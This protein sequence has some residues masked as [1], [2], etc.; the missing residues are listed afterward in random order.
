MKNPEERHYRIVCPLCGRRQED[1]GLTLTCASD[2][3][4]ALLHTEYREKEFRP[5]PEADGIFRYADWLPVVRS[6]PQAGRTVVFRSESLSAFLGM[7]GLRIAFNGYWPERGAFLETCTFKEL[8]AYTV[9]GRL[10]EEPVA[11]VVASAGNTAAAFASVCSRYAKPCL[12]IVPEGGLARLKLRE[13]LHPAVRLVVMDGADYSDAIALS[14]AV[15]KLPGFLLEGGVR[16]VGRRDGL[17]TVMYAAMEEAGEL[18]EYYFQAVGSAAGAI[19]VHEAAKR[20]QRAVP[21]EGDRP[22][23]R[24]MLSQ[25]ASFAPLQQAWH[26]GRRALVPAERD[27]QAI[28]SAYAD[29]LTNRFPPYAVHSGVHDVLTESRGDVLTVDKSSA[30][31]AR[32]KVLDLESIDLE[33]AAAV[34]TA[35]LFAAVSEGRVPRDASVLLNL[36]G[37]GRG[38][39]ARDHVLHQAEPDLRIA[40]G[41]SLDDAL[42][43]I[44]ELFASDLCRQ[45]A[46]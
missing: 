2:H 36:T 14:E 37:G 5:R 1:D 38:R 3:E 20:I 4:P 22:L 6:F 16:N 34:A 13:P 26:S 10:P 41:A 23:P 15:A 28:E 25:N 31:A 7:P 30:L 12:L 18:P 32:Q 43:R 45:S 9:L 29:E 11:L 42:E 40:A 35:S 8:E 39:L 46:T 33:P 19:A 27:R 44:R 21:A 24:L 17:G